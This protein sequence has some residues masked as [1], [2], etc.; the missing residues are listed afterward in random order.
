MHA[1]L[2]TASGIKLVV[3]TRPRLARAA[4]ATVRSSA[5]DGCRWGCRWVRRTAGG[6]VG[7][8]R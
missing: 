5:G 3:V 8:D 6:P 1:L 2:A 4:G 7:L